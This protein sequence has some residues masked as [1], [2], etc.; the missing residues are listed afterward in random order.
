MAYEFTARDVETA[1]DFIWKDFVSSHTPA[2]HPKAFF[3]GGQPG[4]GK[5]IISV[6]LKNAPQYVLCQSGHLPKLSSPIQGNLPR[7]R[8]R[9]RC[10]NRKILRRRHRAP[11]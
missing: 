11:A 3:L 2:A 5:S 8:Y 9:R 4:A 1:A 6:R 7:A 10:G